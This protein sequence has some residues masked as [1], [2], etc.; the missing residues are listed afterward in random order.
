MV[1]ATQV[2]MCLRK[3]VWEEHVAWGHQRT[4]SS[5]ADRVHDNM[6]IGIGIVPLSWEP[7]TGQVPCSMIFIF[8]HLFSQHPIKQISFNQFSNVEAANQQGI[9]TPRAQGALI[10][11]FLYYENPVISSQLFFLLMGVVVME[12]TLL[13]MYLSRQR[14]LPLSLKNICGCMDVFWGEKVASSTACLHLQMVKWLLPFSPE[15]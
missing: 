6:F 9:Q 15:S 4:G 10:L 3:G 7:N 11:S 1:L 12:C 8:I 5:W 2:S 14:I 13:V